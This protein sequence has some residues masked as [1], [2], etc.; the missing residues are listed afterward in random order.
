[1]SALR[2]EWTRP[3]AMNRF[4]FTEEPVGLHVVYDYL[5]RTLLGEVVAAEYREFGC[6]GFFLTVRHF[7]G[8]LWPIQPSARCVRALVRTVPE[9]AE[10]GVW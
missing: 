10:R 9:R 1:M 5:G 6:S 2:G 7:N 4:G 3:I 8:T